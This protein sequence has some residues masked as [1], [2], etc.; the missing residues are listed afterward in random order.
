MLEFIGSARLAI[1]LVSLLILLSAAGALLPQEGPVQPAEIAAWR[2]SHPAWSFIGGYLGLFKVFHS[3]LFL[4]V[5][6]LTALNTLTCTILQLFKR[7][8]GGGAIIKTTGFA[9]LH[10]SLLVLFAGGFASTAFSLDG[11][12]VLTEGQQFS[13]RPNHYVRLSKGPLRTATHRGFTMKLERCSAEYSPD[14]RLLQIHAQLRPG[15]KNQGDTGLLTAG[16]NH[17]AEYSGF[18]FTLDQTGFSP[19]IRFSKDNRVIFESYIALK[20]LQEG[21][22]REYRDTI[23]TP[24]PGKTIITLFPDHALA[25]DGV[26]K[27]TGEEPGDPVLLVEMADNNGNVNWHRHVKLGESIELGSYRLEFA[28]LRRWASFRVMEDPGYPIILIGLWL[29]IAGLVT[30]YAPDVAEWFTSPGNE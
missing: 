4:A 11:Y 7:K 17:P 1:V 18:S 30:R 15:L 22:F 8:N 20:T 6:L 9:L 25:A 29:G 10:L 16:I 5:I 26:L 2:V 19:L 13:E 27:K 28:G 24:L 21:H 3:P 14:W 23:R 12:I